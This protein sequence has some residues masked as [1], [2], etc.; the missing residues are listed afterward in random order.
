MATSMSSLL[1]WS[2]I[3]LAC[4]HLSAAA[5]PAAALPSASDIKISAEALQSWLVSTRR[6]LH[7]I[8]ELGFQEHKTSKYIADFLTHHNISFR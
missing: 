1:A 3:A 8:P 4:A 2:L 7:Q 5:T 6:D